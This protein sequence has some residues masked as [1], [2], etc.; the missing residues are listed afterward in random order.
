MPSRR[1]FLKQLAQVGGL[2]AAAPLLAPAL[3]AN[4]P[5]VQSLGNDALPAWQ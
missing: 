5:Q 2:A 1:Q 4:E 3:S